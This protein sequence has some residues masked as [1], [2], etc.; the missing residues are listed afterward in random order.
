MIQ[1]SNLHETSHRPAVCLDRFPRTCSPICKL[2]GG[3]CHYSGPSLRNSALCPHGAPSFGGLAWVHSPRETELQGRGQ[4]CM[5]CLKIWLPAGFNPPLPLDSVGQSKSEQ[6]SGPEDAE[7][8][9][10]SGGR[11]CK[12]T[13]KSLRIEMCKE[14][15]CFYERPCNPTGM[16]Q[17]LPL[18]RRGK[19]K[20]PRHPVTL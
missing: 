4:K 20:Q 14:S 19:H 11:D 9:Y 2:A 16:P 8:H 3:H 17:P 12:H 10:N 18:H 5:E 7:R 13:A 1:R 15:G 6:Q